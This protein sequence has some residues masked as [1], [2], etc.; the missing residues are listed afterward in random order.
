MDKKKRSEKR[1]RTALVQVRCTASEKAAIERLAE[2][3]GVSAAELMRS[4]S[5]DYPLPDIPPEDVANLLMA[6]KKLGTNANQIAHAANAH[7]LANAHA[8]WRP[9]DETV[10]LRKEVS[11][12]RKY[13]LENFGSTRKS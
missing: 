13:V 5:L 11:A 6:I 12:L 3:R 9:D 1:Q 7:N 4:S 2:S 10:R 8:T